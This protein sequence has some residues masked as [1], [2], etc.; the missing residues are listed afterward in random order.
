MTPQFHPILVNGPFDD[1]AVYVDFLYERRALLFDLGDIRA[2]PPRKIL[3]LTHIFIS[4][5]HIDHF[6]GFDHL[7]RL[8]LGHFSMQTV[9]GPATGIT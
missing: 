8:C 2:L 5:T 3:R 9:N 7:L 1:P 4:H 6:I